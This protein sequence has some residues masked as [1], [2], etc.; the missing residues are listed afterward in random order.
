[1]ATQAEVISGLKSEVAVLRAQV[2]S[3]R[4]ESE[5]LRDM[6]ARTAVIEHRLAEITKTKELW[7]QRS[8]AILTI[9]LSALFSFLAVVLGSLLTFY[10]NSKK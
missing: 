1:V 6:A 9:C 8:W 2:E 4:K 10:L 5:P 7:G 3:L